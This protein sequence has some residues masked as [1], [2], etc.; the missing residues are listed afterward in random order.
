MRCKQSHCR[1]INCLNNYKKSEDEQEYKNVGL[2]NEQEF[3]KDPEP[4]I[5]E[6]IKIKEEIDI[7]EH[8][9]EFIPVDDNQ[10]N[11]VNTTFFFYFLY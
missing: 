3:I 8:K 1:L 7:E 11:E 4:E 2:N 5:N 10:F 6:L 9:I